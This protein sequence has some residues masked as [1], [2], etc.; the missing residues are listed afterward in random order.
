MGPT[1]QEPIDDDDVISDEKYGS[2]ENEFDI[3]STEDD[4]SN[5]S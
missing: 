3:I 1:F 4:A 5:A 2:A